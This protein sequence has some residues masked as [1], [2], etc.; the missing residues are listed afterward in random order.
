VSDPP[1]PFSFLFFSRRKRPVVEFR[2]IAPLLPQSFLFFSPPPPLLFSARCLLPRESS[3]RVRPFYPSPLPFSL[4]PFFSFFFF[5]RVEAETVLLKSRRRQPLRHVVCPLFTSFFL[6]PLFSFFFSGSILG[7][8][9]SEAEVVREVSNSIPTS[10]FFSFPFFSLP[11]PALGKLKGPHVKRSPTPSYPLL[12]SPLLFPRK[13]WL[14]TSASRTCPHA[15]LALFFFSFFD[16]EVSCAAVCSPPPPPL[17]FPLL[18]K[19]CDCFKAPLV[20]FL[21]FFFFCKFDGR[22]LK[23]TGSR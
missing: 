10:L 8:D 19:L 3:Q 1:P 2:P 17:L 16:R 22:E 11:R 13:R 9:R 15:W 18:G 23:R 6:L 14:K 5:L 20:V 4:P 12:F 21:P 7:G